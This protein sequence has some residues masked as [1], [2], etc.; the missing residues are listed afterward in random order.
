MKNRLP[1]LVAILGLSSA[2]DIAFAQTW[3]RTSAP[4][5]NYSQIVVSPD[6]SKLVAIA[7][8]NPDV[9]TSTNSGVSWVTT[10]LT[11]AG[12]IVSSADGSRWALAAGDLD[13]WVSTNSGIVWKPTGG[14]G[15]NVRSV[16]LS[17]D[18]NIIVAN[19]FGNISTNFGATWRYS[20]GVPG[21]AVTLAANGTTW[22]AGPVPF[23]STAKLFVST[24]LGITWTTNLLPNTN[25]YFPAFS[26]DG[27]R[28]AAVD[29]FLSLPT[30]VNPGCIY[31]STN[32]G[33]SWLKT[34]APSN[35]W[36]GIASSAD[37][38]KLVAVAVPQKAPYVPA[39]G[40]I[41]TSTDGGL[42]W[43]TNNAPITNWITVA[44]S[45][46]GSKL[47][48]AVVGGG[49][50]TADSTPTPRLNT[51]LASNIFTLSWILPSTNFVLQQS[52]D[53]SNWTD[54]TDAPTLNLTNLREEVV[55]PPTN[56]CGFYRLKTP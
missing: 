17:A 5:E 26:A 15:G 19:S 1:T 3:V 10:N 18:G 47:A 14:G 25:I 42:S 24:N 12:P 30:V 41:F 36:T 28:I 34:A 8:A 49:I 21:G 45:A 44:S 13:V 37:G 6:G 33:V 22:I 31:V 50:Y 40:G 38:R 51:T 29:T 27:S 39:N 43:F 9:F 32:F 54:M 35:Y 7:S 11:G 2:W 16:A 53:L 55:L 46:D 23:T 48:A 52:A 4:N 56:T 20:S